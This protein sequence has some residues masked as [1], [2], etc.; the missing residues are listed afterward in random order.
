MKYIITLY[1]LYC[2]AVF[3]LEFVYRFT[4]FSEF[5]QIVIMW[6]CTS[7]AQ[8]CPDGTVVGR[9]GPNCSFA[10]C[11][12][13]E[14]IERNTRHPWVLEVQQLLNKTSC[15]VSAFGAG[16]PGQETN[17]FGSKTHG[18]LECYSNLGPF[19]S[20][21]IT[22]SLLDGLRVYVKNLTSSGY[23]VTQPDAR[24]C[25]ESRSQCN[26]CQRHASSDLWRCTQVYCDDEKF[27]CVRWSDSD[28]AG[29][30]TE[31]VKRNTR[32][33]WVLE[34]QRLLNQTQCQVSVHGPGSPGQETN[35]FGNKTYSALECYV[36]LSGHY[37][38]DIIQITRSLVDSLQEYVDSIQG[39]IQIRKHIPRV[40]ID[41][42]SSLFGE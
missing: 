30:V 39:P 7:D 4:F 10:P 23:G 34:V 24:F 11:P 37:T 20:G 25:L 13:V 15:Q 19:Y 12:S 5:I 6:S 33:P 32:H 3:L 40:Y 36:S 17:Y 35:Y 8:M 22:E 38:G 41:D 31:I 26:T 27:S 28:V 29:S 18:A 14:T 42:F 1:L 9:T 2:T 21:V 16:S